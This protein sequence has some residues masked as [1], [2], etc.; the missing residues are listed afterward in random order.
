MT[1]EGP[2]GLIDKAEDTL[3][4]IYVEHLRSLAER[5]VPDGGEL[6]PTGA[7][8][9]PAEVRDEIADHVARVK[10]QGFTVIENVVPPDRVAG[11]R[12]DVVKAAELIKAEWEEMNARD[13][14]EQ[15]TLRDPPG[16]SQV[17]HLLS[18][19]PYFGDERMVGVARGLLDPH[20][21]IAQCEA[22]GG[23][24]RPPNDN[25]PDY[26]EWHSD[27][28]HDLTAGPHSGSIAQPFP[29]VTMALSTVWYLSD[30]GPQSGGTWAVPYSHRDPRNPRG[31]L[32]GIDEQAPIPGEVQI[33]APAG[34]VYVQD[35]RCWHSVA[36]NPG[37]IARIGLVLIYA[38][39]WL[40]LEFSRGRRGFA[41]ANGARIPRETFEQL[42]P[43]VQELVRHRADG[44][45][46]EIGDAKWYVSAASQL[47][48]RPAD[49][50][51]VRVRQP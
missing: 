49:N 15:Q 45:A 50:S 10:E 1:L 6:F 33:T 30:A 7:P 36:A 17:A 18:L 39:W 40:N 43:S 29:D 51:H 26:R 46:D 38:P 23:T 19:A 41:G 22:V 47:R 8:Y 14:R 4:P 25:R 12:E 21:R 24:V 13:W 5:E 32:D 11:I 34:S 3:S 2:G 27:W 42:P 37:P 9:P 44:Q 20:V 48:E 31:I 35:T 28:P 16:I